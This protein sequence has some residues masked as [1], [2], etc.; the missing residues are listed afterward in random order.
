MIYYTSRLK[1]ILFKFLIIIINKWQLTGMPLFS[2]QNNMLALSRF[3]HNI[4]HL[5]APEI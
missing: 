5:M 4:H 2:N 1:N 3:Y